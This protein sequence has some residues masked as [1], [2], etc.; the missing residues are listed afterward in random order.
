MPDESI[1]ASGDRPGA[2][3]ATQRYLQVDG[4][5]G[6]A[7]VVVL[8]MH[9]TTSYD[10]LVGHSSKMLLS[11]PYGGLGVH[12]FF[13]L[14]GFVILLSI[15]R[16]RR[17]ADFC[18]SRFARLYP[19]Y[20]TAALVTLLITYPARLPGHELSPGAIAANV[21]MLQGF[22]GYVH[23][24]PVYWTLQAELQFYVVVGLIV[25][26]R[27]RKHILPV[28]AS[29]VLLDGINHFVKFTDWRGLGLW[30]FAVYLPADFLYLFLIGMTFYEMRSGF[31]WRHAVFLAIS[32]G[33]ATLHLS[34]FKYAI[35]GG[36]AV[37]LWL[38]T[39]D[40]IPIFANRVLVFLGVISYSLYLVHQFVGYAVITK[41]YS[42]GLNGN[43]AIVVA[44]LVV[45]PLSIAICFLV[46]RP[47]NE[48]IKS[49]YKLWCN[50]RNGPSAKSETGC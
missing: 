42:L 1:P 32:A 2:A 48:W 43:L 44:I 15:D 7:A 17:L 41:C 5:R 35:V 22:L 27:M 19:A 18:V 12:L 8:L 40:L 16:S 31:Q 34:P 11:V 21:T 47:A 14:S 13:M 37:L 28:F 20:W 9:Y 6:A 26:L 10:I 39:R 23:I 3:R 25:A 24:D 38:A 30:R 29:L 45:V 46:E 49:R 4:L 36:S 50:A 33:I